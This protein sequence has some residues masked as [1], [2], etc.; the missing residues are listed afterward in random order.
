MCSVIQQ[1]LLFG[2][3]AALSSLHGCGDGES[4]CLVLVMA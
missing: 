4:L 2:E 3:E 1:T